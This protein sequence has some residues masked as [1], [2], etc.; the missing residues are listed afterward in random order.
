MRSLP[1][2]SEITSDSLGGMQHLT[3]LQH[4]YRKQGLIII[5]LASRGKYGSTLERASR[6]VAAKGRAVD[7]R[8]AWDDRGRT[9]AQWMAVERREGWPWAFIIDRFGRVA[10]IGHPERMDSSLKQILEGRSSCLPRS[11][12]VVEPR[13]RA[14]ARYVQERD[15]PTVDCGATRF[16]ESTLHF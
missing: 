10:Y 13:I 15:D 11:K 16:L 1:L 7:Y 3:D 12:G 4:R 9:Y 6:A 8:I 14:D 2:A 5:G